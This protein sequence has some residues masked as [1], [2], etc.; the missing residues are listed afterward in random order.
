MLAPRKVLHSTPAYVLSA[1]FELAEVVATDTVLD[2]GCGDGRALIHAAV[3]LGARG[4]GW[5]INPELAAEAAAAVAADGRARGR[6]DI[7]EGNILSVSAPQLWPLFE[8][9]FTRADTAEGLVIILYLSPYG[10]RKLLPMIRPAIEARRAA[11]LGAVRILSYIYPFPE[12]A[13]DGLWAHTEKHWCTDQANPDR[14]FPL[15]YYRSKAQLEG[16]R[17]SMVVDAVLPAAPGASSTAGSVQSPAEGISG[18]QASSNASRTNLISYEE[19]AK[20]NRNGDCWIVV[21][22]KVYDVTSFIADHPGGSDVILSSAGADSTVEF[23]DAH[24][25]SII[26]VALGAAGVASSFIGHADPSTA[27]TKRTGEMQLG[28]HCL[29]TGAVMF[30]VAIVV[31]VGTKR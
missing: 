30:L 23:L 3:Q 22:C 2:V 20:H 25:E 13:G 16:D 27:P 29:M 4:Y 11:G 14:S 1:A 7:F 9:L 28:G 26:K 8:A 31:G 24:P 5:E 12:A 6:V 19:I 10:V 17:D 18:N 15:F 21:N